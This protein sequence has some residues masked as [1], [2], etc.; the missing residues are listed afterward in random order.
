MQAPRSPTKGD[1][2]PISPGTVSNDANMNPTEDDEV[3]API[4][5]EAVS[6]SPNITVRDSPNTNLTVKVRRKAAKRTLPFDL[7]SEE[8]HIMPSSWSSQ[9][10][11]IPT[12][13]R[14]KPRLEEP[15]PTTT[16]EAGRK[17]ASPSS[18]LPSPAADNDDTNA[19]AMTG[20]Q[21]NAVAAGSWTLEENAKLN[22]AVTNTPKKSWGK[23]YITD[24]VA[25]AALIPGRTRSQCMKRWNTVLDPS[26]DRA[27]PGR[28]GKWAE[29]EDSKLKDAVQ[30]HG[31]N[32]WVAVSVL[33]PG[34]TRLQCRNR[35]I[36]VLDPIIGRAN[37]RKGKWAEAEDSKLKDAVQTH[38]DND[39]VAVSVLVPGRTRLQCRNRWIDVLDPSIDRANGRTGEWEEVEDSKL[40]GG[41]Q[42]HGGKD[43]AAVAALLPGRTK[44]Q[45]RSRW[46]RVLN[47]SI[48]QANGRTG[49]WAEDEDIKLRDAVQ[50]HGD[51]NWA[52]IAALVPGRTKQ[53]C[54]SRWIDVLDPI[55]GRANGRTG[56]WAE[57]ED[58]KLKDAVQTHGGKDWAAIAAMVPGRTKIQCRN[59]WYDALDPI[60]GRANGRTGKWAEDEDSKLKDAVQTHGGKDWAAIAALVPGRTKI[61]CRNRWYDALDP[62]NDRVSGRTGKWA[63]DEDS[64]LKDAV[65]T[66]GGKDWAA[67]AA[68]VPGRT[69]IQ[70]R[71]RWHGPNRITVRGK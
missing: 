47:P 12:V 42:T 44:Q 57:D 5:P 21:P 59:R 1:K 39:W 35:W 66:H 13:A 45:C 48:D 53:Q 36:D 18:G 16:D 68:L 56:K 19:D 11:D 22:I 69:K 46:Y 27:P 23:K 20:T 54:R 49:V 10:D 40:K 55:I 62:S 51:K 70:C 26:I 61:Q 29:A 65:K 43:W 25:V 24:W 3:E 60:I 71:D 34:R 8:L 52:A 17:T 15:P 28:T 33:V 14:K 64:K 6:S 37:G 4:S 31:D 63:E 30:T 41:V 2:V 32:D 50:T 9:A 67:I 38:G 7:A 58:S